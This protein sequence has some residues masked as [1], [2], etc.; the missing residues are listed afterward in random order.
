[1]P[2]FD[3]L[4]I[5]LVEDSEDD[6]FFFRRLFAK[7]GI[8]APITV[9]TNGH[10][11]IRHFDAALNASDGPKPGLPRLVF[12][13][14]KL[15]LRSGFEVLQWMR[16]QPSL[17]HVIVMVLSSSAET[18]DIAEAF[19]LGAQGYVVKYPSPAAFAEIVRTVADLPADADLKKLT[20]PGLARPKS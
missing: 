11:A 5:L 4:P 18:R 1:M 9:V 14:L 10:N 17:A 8:T 7:A 16:S 3:H 19:A 12:L 6:L 20:L 15:P 2:A 13:D